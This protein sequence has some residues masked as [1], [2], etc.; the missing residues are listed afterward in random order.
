[1][2]VRPLALNP[3]AC[4][5]ALPAVEV[6]AAPGVTLM[7]GQVKVNGPCASNTAQPFAS[8]ARIVKL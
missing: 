6:S 8:T 1:M 7:T 2:P 5:K 4:V 3:V